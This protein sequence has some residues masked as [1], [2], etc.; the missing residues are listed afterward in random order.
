MIKNKILTTIFITIFVD[1][2]GVGILIPVFPLLINQNSIYKITPATW[3][4]SDGLIMSGW[5][6]AVYPLGQFLFN[7]ILGQLS[8]HFGR[9]RILSISIFGTTLSYILFAIGIYSHSIILVF[10]S[11]LLDGITGANISVAQASIAD[12]SEQKDRAKNFGLV[13]IALGLG[14]ILGPFL[15]GVFS[16]NSI[17]PYFNATTPFW[18]ATLLSLINLGLIKIFL[19]ETL[20]IYSKE[21]INLMSSIDNIKKVFVNKNIT[22]VVITSFLFS[23]GFNSYTVF[24]GIILSYY[25]GFSQSS[26]GNFFGFMGIAIVLAQGVLVRNLSGKYPEELILRYSIVAT[27]FCLLGYYLINTKYSF[28]LYYF[29]PFLAISVSV[30]RAFISS[31]LSKLAT[32]KTQGEVMGINSSAMALSQV[33]PAILAGYIATHHV[34]SV[35]LVGAILTFIGGI[36]FIN[37]LK[38]NH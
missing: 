4:Y 17:C 1:M 9:K 20:K 32:S 29:I 19:P 16:D 36:Y 2:L 11:R 10:L 8:D 30:T 15:G 35:I 37:S 38:N 25:Y 33:F 22:S 26:I 12:I 13:G 21:K 18:I 24:W 7:P 6:L 3:S 28:L 34:K 23:I 14:F 27:G 5:L 31:Y